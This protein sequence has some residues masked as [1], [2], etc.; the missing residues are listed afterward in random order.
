MQQLDGNE[1][2]EWGEEGK[3]VCKQVMQGMR[4]HV[5]AKVGC[6]MCRLQDVR[7]AGCEGCRL[8]G[9]DVFFVHK[10]FPCHF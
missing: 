9:I 5:T 6:R 2:S 3:Q 7:G 1:N 10:F 4:V 8:Q